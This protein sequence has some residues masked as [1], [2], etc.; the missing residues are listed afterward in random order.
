VRCEAC[1][2]PGREHAA[3][4][5]KAAILDPRR[6]EPADSVDFC[7]ACHATFWDVKLAGEKGVAALRSQPHRLQSSR[8]WG[9]G[10]A[11][12]TCVACHD[13]HRPLVRETASYDARCLACHVG[14]EERPTAA[15][16][17]KACPTRSEGCAGCHM[18]KY[19]VAEMHFRFTDHLI[20]VVPSRLR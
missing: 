18:P 10:D 5:R 7:G 12:L 14:G 19:Q 15:R 17:G 3:S 16:P 20:R 11:R 13:P 4:G 9:E 8:C 2:G 1:H 6:L